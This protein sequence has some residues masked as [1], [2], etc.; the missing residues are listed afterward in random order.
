MGVDWSRLVVITRK[1]VVVLFIFV[2]L[3]II[4]LQA[5]VYFPKY[6]AI[7]QTGTDMAPQFNRTVTTTATWANFSETNITGS[8]EPGIIPQLS[9]VEKCLLMERNHS[10]VLDYFDAFNLTQCSY[11]NSSHEITVYVNH[12][13]STIPPSMCPDHVQYQLVKEYLLLNDKCRHTFP[14]TK[15]LTKYVHLYIFKVS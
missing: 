8:T 14:L 13:L 10:I 11:T 6:V 15:T 9:I 5:K 7:E 2:I 3:L 4:Y 12:T 1:N